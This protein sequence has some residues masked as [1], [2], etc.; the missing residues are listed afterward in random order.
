M[1]KNIFRLAMFTQLAYLFYLQQN[2]CVKVTEHKILNKKIP[3]NF[4]G[5]KIVQ[6][7]D[8]HC[9]KVGISDMIFF[10]KIRRLKPDIIVITGD[11]LDSYR[12]NSD[13]AYNI[14]ANVSN[15]APTYFVSGNHE[16]RL[17]D[18]YEKLKEQLDKLN[19]VNLSNK[20]IILEREN[21]KISLSGVED[22]K[23]FYRQDKENYYSMYRKQLISSYTENLYNILLAHRPEKFHLYSDLG[24]DLTLSG[25]AHGGQWNIP[26]IGRIYAP[27][28]GYFPK[29]TNGIYEEK[30]ST[31]IVSQGL[32]NSS[33][34]TRINNRLE[35]ISIILEND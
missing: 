22:F 8:I 1:N 34:P 13:I 21:K 25:H 33:F 6:L 7:S 19:I 18:E 5:F 9:E 30:Q 24:F 10:E 27:S 29:Y 14:L 20:K 4:N 11:I 26:F 12:N 17:S 3:N 28:Q 15:I 35:I 23:Y 31:M 16:I 32:G 2:K